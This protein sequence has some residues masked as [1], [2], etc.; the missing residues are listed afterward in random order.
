[1]KKKD[2]KK[3]RNSLSFTLI[4]LLVVIAII[5][6]LASMLLPA[7]NQA[8]DKA[9]AIKCASNLKQI[10]TCLTM[11]TNDYDGYFPAKTNN[12]GRPGAGDIGWYKLMDTTSWAGSGKELMYCPKDHVN[13]QSKS[14]TNFTNGH[15]SY[16]INFE[17][18]NARKLLNAKSPSETVAVADTAVNVST[19]PKGYYWA[20]GER[21]DSLSVAYNWHGRSANILWVDGH[22]SAL[23]V[24][25]WTHLYLNS[26]LLG[27]TGLTPTTPNKWDLE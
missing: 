11:Y 5:A 13:I 27:G 18:L 20:S 26:S 23:N 14:S 10:G 4:E 3:S 22:V 2:S 25:Y 8:R 19:N 7:L 15:I 21:N 24:S 16:G 12:V 1:M 6:I 17:N 9:H